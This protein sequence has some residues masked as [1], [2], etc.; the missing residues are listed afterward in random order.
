[1]YACNPIFIAFFATSQP[2]WKRHYVDTFY[3]SL[4]VSKGSQRAAKPFLSDFAEAISLP[5]KWQL[6]RGVLQ[7]NPPK[8]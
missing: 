2:N 1:M 3:K 5:T 6:T 4:W 7:L 8:R